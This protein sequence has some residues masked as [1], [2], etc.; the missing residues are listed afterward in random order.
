MSKLKIFGKANPVVGK[1]EY[2]SIHDFFG[3]SNPASFDQLQFPSLSDEHVKWSIWT[4]SGSSWSK[5]AENDKTGT[6]VHYTFSQKSLTRK[7]IRMLV[8]AN[9]EKAVLDIKTE[10]ATQGKILHVELLDN[11][12]NKLTRPFAYGDWIIARVH[13]VDMELLPVKVTLWEDDGDKTKQNTTNVRIETKISDILNGIAYAKFY[14]DPSHAWLANA[15]LAKGDKN[16]GEFHEYYVTAE[17]FEKISKRVPSK[18]VNIPNPDYK[19]EAQAPKK[20]TPAEKK[21]PSKKEQKGIAK[22]DNKVH[23]YHETKVS[24]KNE[25]S[26]NPVWEKINSM[27]MVNMGGVWEIKKE[28]NCGEKY[29]IKKGDKSELIREINIRLAGFGGNVPTDEF[30]DRTEKM[31]KQFQR[32]YMQVPETGK[33]CGNVLKAIDE[34]QVKYLIHFNDIKCKCGKCKG[35]GNEKFKAHK[36]NSKIAEAYRK[37]EY[38]GIHRS[39]VWALRS[40]MFYCSSKEKELGYSVKCVA[41]GYRCDEDNK[42]HNRN[43]TNHMGKALDIHFNK[44]GKRTL[45]SSGIILEMEEIRLKIFNKYLGAKWD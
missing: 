17:I 39:L 40:V 42:Q 11:N 41:S 43:T 37:Y 10:R 4:F 24:I 30:T 21:G 6:T 28:K 8:E 13:C 32:D 23:D 34:F 22:S 5:R 31:I 20:Q 12:Y 1:K 9:G 35:F 19:P 29:C 38:P 25:I 27:M 36:Q 14:L 16:E 18:N 45:K 3:S 2:Y 44:N 7:G 33:V 26:T 15:K